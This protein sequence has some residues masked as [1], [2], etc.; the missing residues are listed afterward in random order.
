M[1]GNIVIPTYIALALLTVGLG[2]LGA[3]VS[4]VW[5][6]GRYSA[7]IEGQLNVMST[8]IGALSDRIYAIEKR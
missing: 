7:T 4:L 1:S 3:L 6:S 5:R 2:Q 8:R